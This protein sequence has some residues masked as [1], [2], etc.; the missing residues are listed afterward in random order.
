MLKDADISLDNTPNPGVIKDQVAVFLFSKF[1]TS[2]L[3][4]IIGRMR[5]MEMGEINYVRIGFLNKNSNQSHIL[6]ARCQ[7]L[8]GALMLNSVLK[9]MSGWITVI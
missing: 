2:W 4:E 8:I 6:H 9:G 1:K 5:V 7:N 3:A